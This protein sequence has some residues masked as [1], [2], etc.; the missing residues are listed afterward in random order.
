MGKTK[1]KKPPPYFYEGPPLSKQEKEEQTEDIY[2]TDVR[3]AM[4]DVDEVTAAEEGFMRGRE[5]EPPSKKETRKKAVSHD[6]EISVELAKE[7]TEED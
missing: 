1:A 2:D 3:E 6:D 5:Q 7:D 4:L